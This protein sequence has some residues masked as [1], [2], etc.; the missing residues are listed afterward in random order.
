[1]RGCVGVL[2]RQQNIQIRHFVHIYEVKICIILK[3]KYTTSLSLFY[4]NYLE[5]MSTIPVYLRLKPKSKKS[6][7]SVPF[8]Q[9]NKESVIVKSKTNEQHEYKF[10]EIF[11]EKVQQEEIFQK[12]CL[13]L[14]DRCLN[15]QDSI[16]FTL[17]SSNSG[18]VCLFM[19]F[20]EK[21]D[22]VSG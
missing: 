2:P 5:K 7:S 3:F 16:M 13:P 4:N 18:K 1:M 8:L 15:G 21:V 12:V 11:D 6:V 19:L 17:G 9:P 20:N 22:N 10:T 14:V